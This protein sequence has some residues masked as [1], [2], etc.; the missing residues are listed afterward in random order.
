MFKKKN[1][2][3]VTQSEMN[4][5]IGILNKIY[6][7]VKELNRQNN[8]LSQ[9]Y[10]GDVKLTRIHKRLQEHGGLGKSERKLFEALVKVKQDADEQVLNNS[11]IV[12][13]EGYFERHMMSFV[14]RRMQEQQFILDPDTSRYINHLVVDEYLKEFNTGSRVW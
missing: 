8:Q 12:D 3:E 14:L 13:N 7:R 11:H 5:N 1:L 6:D 10:D 9:K 4:E 2:S